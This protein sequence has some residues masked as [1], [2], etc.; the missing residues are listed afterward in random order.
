MRSNLSGVDEGAGGVAFLGELMQLLADVDLI[1]D[2]DPRLWVDLVAAVHPG[3]DVVGLF[4]VADDERDLGPAWEGHGL[5]RGR[6][7]TLNRSPGSPAEAEAPGQHPSSIGRSS[8]SD[9][10]RTRSLSRA[11]SCS[12]RRRFRS[13][14]IAI[15]GSSSSIATRRSEWATSA[16]AWSMARFSRGVRGSMASRIS[17]SWSLCPPR[18]G[19]TV[20]DR[21]RGIAATPRRLAGGLGWS[22]SASLCRRGCVRVGGARFGG[23]SLFA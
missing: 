14:R 6:P 5:T 23:V 3:V 2:F 16:R 13:E 7:S 21:R 17:S 20:G 22:G 1:A 10:R 11:T 18:F 15:S 8:C 12:A 4:L 9:S 19:G